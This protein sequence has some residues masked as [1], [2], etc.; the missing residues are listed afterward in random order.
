MSLAEPLASAGGAL[1]AGVF[2]QVARLRGTRALHAVGVCG[3]GSL[4]VEPGPPSGVVL[5]DDP[6]PHPCLLRW[7]RS[8]GRERGRDVE[9]LALRVEGPAAGDVLLSSTGTGVVGRHLLVARRHDHHGPL[10][11]LLPLSTARGPLLLRLDPTTP[12][13]DAPDEPPTAYR[14]MVAA[15]GRPWHERGALTITWTRRDCTRRHDPVGHPPA[16]AWTHPLLARLR[17]P[18]YAASQQVAAT[19]ETP[20][21][22]P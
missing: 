5:L 17:D 1:L 14:L 12:G 20:E 7:S 4:T 22:T 13:G 19:P 9:G 11:T 18:S 10:T 8:V 16:G 3:A 2:G 15:P 6:G 21:E